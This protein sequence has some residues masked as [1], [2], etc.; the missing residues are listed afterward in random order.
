MIKTLNFRTHAGIE[1]TI[2]HA[3]S[4]RKK[5]E[6]KKVNWKA[7]TCEEFLLFFQP[8]LGPILKFFFYLIGS[9]AARGGKRPWDSNFLNRFISANLKD[10]NELTS[11]QKSFHSG[12]THGLNGDDDC[13]RISIFNYI[14]LYHSSQESD[15][16]QAG[17]L[18]VHEDQCNDKII[19]FYFC[20]PLKVC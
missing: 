12:K 5:K 1:W 10:D 13:Q 14:F 6:K 18:W 4:K 17:R 3:D 2:Y 9:C 11:N 20:K 15:N 16:H 19:Q 7:Q 8:S